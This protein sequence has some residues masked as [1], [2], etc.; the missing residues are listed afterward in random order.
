MGLE[1]VGRTLKAKAAILAFISNP[2]RA[3]SDVGRRPTTECRCH[4]PGVGLGV[5][6]E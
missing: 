6:Q 3:S 4:G 5:G 2:T 1:Y